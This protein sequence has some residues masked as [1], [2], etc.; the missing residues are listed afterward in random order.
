MVE[1][2][3]ASVNL[4]SFALDP[5]EHV[6]PREEIRYNYLLIYMNGSLRL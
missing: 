2:S 3:K 5:S 1:N 6:D 4:A